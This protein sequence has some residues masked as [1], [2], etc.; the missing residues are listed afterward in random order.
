MLS[1]TFESAQIV[2]ST[3]GN[4]NSC[5]VKGVETS[6]LSFLLWTLQDGFKSSPLFRFREIRSLYFNGKTQDKATCRVIPNVLKAKTTSLRYFQ[7]KP[8]LLLGTYSVQHGSYT[9]HA[10]Q[11]FGL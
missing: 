8:A 7:T 2:I 11:K 6:Q 1:K 10:L 9:K 4:S 3:H 5:A